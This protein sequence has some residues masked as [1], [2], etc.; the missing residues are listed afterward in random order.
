M[1][2]ATDGGDQVNEFDIEPMLQEGNIS[3]VNYCN[4]IQQY[5]WKL[6]IIYL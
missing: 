4:V 1:S 6:Y 5:L 3:R 2:V